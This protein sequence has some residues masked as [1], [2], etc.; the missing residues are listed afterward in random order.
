LKEN[1]KQVYENVKYE[2]IEISKELSRCQTELIK[3]DHP[4]KFHSHNISIFDWK[5]TFNDECVIIALE[6]LDNLPHDKVTIEKD[7]YYQIEVQEYEK[8]EVKV[9]M[10]D[11]YMIQ[12]MDLIDLRKVYS[13]NKNLYYRMKDFFVRELRY[14][15][16]TLFGN[17]LTAYIPTMQLMMLMIFLKKFPK[18]NLILADFDFLPTYSKY[19]FGIFYLIKGLLTNPMSKAS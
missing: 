10:T 12:Y 11:P 6:V 9:P 2:I 7:I 14:G 8:K 3:K 15:S 1:E 5:Q 17:F 19:E 13:G 18:H 16:L 4:N